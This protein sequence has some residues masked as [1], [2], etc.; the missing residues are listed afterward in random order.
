VTRFEREVLHC[1]GFQADNLLAPFRHDVEAALHEGK[2]CCQESGRVLRFHEDG[3][4]GY[5]YLAEAHAQ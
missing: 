2:I 1:V 4:H 5:T 3:L